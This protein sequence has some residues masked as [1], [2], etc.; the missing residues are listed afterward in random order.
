MMKIVLWIYVVLLCVG[1]LIGYL[2]AGSIISLITSVGFAIPLALCA[3]GIL[4]R[5][6][7]YVLTGFLGAFF[8][9]RLVKSG[10]FMPAGLMA[11]V[12]VIVLILLFLV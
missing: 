6:V 8:L 9:F 11:V 2:K 5:W 4:P 7:A 3:L 1:G 12:S 10:K